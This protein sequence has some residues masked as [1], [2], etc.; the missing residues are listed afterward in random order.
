MTGSGHGRRYE[1]AFMRGL[2]DR[3]AAQGWSLVR[4]ARECRISLPTLIR[5]RRKLAR[6]T[7][8]RF[9]ELVHAAA[10]SQPPLPPSPQPPIAGA[11][12]EVVF[13][14][15]VRLL[16]RDAGISDE[17]LVRVLR[18]MARSAC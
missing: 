17:L 16:V 3:A 15:G 13:P 4:L 11:S 1:P 6:E 12:V 9:V 10:D 18:A 2:L 7:V 14:G 5:W 8:P